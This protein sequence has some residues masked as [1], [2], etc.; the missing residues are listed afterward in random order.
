[1]LEDYRHVRGQFSRIVSIEMLEAVGHTNLPA[2]FEAIDRL[3]APGG[4]AVLQ[5]IT[6]PDRKYTRLSLRFRLDPQAHL[7]RRA[8]AVIWGP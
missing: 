4:R 3:L 6:M 8:S 7:P 5:V 1:M 2:Y